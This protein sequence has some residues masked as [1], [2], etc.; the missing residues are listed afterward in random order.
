[1]LLEFGAQNFFCFKEGV[2]IS[3]RLGS[4]CPGYISNGK[5]FTNVLCVK[6]ANGSG[7]T[8]A[9]KIIPFLNNFC[10][11]SFSRKPE[12]PIYYES[13]FRNKDESFIYV[14]FIVDDVT[15]RYE[16]V[17]SRD[18]VI[19][20][21]IFRK[22]KRFSPIV[23]RKG[24]KLKN[25]INEYK[26]LGVIKK[27]RSNAS[28][29]STAHQYEID[30]MEPI[31][32]FFRRISS[33]VSY[34]GLMHASN[35]TESAISKLY[36]E[37]SEV[38]G[39]S[40]EL[41]HKFDE[42]IYDIKV[43]QK[44]GSNPEVEEKEYIPVFLHKIDE[45]VHPLPIFA[46]SSGTQSLYKQLWRY[47]IMLEMGGV[48]VL[49]EFDINL[50]PDILPWLIKLFTDEETNPNNAQLVFSTHNTEVLDVLGKYRTVFVAK[51]ENESFAYRL[52]EI[53]GDILRNDRP[54]VPIYKTG[55]IGGVPK[56]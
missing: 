9:L 54:I 43:I 49:D 8:N 4:K 48:L 3:L 32:N 25:C 45:E 50:H 15:Y 36:F 7:K 10:C 11:N 34:A 12:E 13:F 6:G 44:D 35:D 2:E 16:L 37:H 5:S 1:M 42:A 53:P 51:E 29:V 39:F 38:L 26:E 23:E 21:C 22:K 20:E 52:D 55:R 56:L 47:K 46:E 17:S 27:L 24:N 40:K 28:I 18:E 19:S 33:N 30:C 31:Y 41:I 14:E